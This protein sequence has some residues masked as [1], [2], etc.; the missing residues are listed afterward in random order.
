MRLFEAMIDANHRAASGDHFYSRQ[1][2][3]HLM[4][5]AVETSN[6]TP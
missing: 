4:T 5:I 1:R 6:L 3:L 2:M